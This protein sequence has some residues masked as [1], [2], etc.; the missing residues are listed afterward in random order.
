MNKNGGVFQPPEKKRT[1][2]NTQKKKTCWVGKVVRKVENLDW[3]ANGKVSVA[4]ICVKLHDAQGK[5]V[6]QKNRLPKWCDEQW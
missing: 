5:K 3:N 2:F 4:W 1:C 6:K